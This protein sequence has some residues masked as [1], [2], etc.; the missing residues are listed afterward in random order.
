MPI[1]KHNKQGKMESSEWRKQ[2]NKRKYFKLREDKRKELETLRKNAEERAQ[3]K[4]E[5]VKAEAL[6]NKPVE[7]PEKVG[8]IKRIYNW[9]RGTK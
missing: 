2:K 1:S 8:T 3:K 9:I 6:I 4:R 7:K 5:A